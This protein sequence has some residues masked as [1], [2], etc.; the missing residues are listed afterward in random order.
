MTGVNNLPLFLASCVALNVMPG[1]D[2][3]YIVT[4]SVA[5]GRRAGLLSS[6][7]LCTGALLHTF[8]AALGLS[9]VL[10]ASAQ[11]FTLVKYAGALYLMYLGVKTFFDT[12][13]PLDL[14]TKPRAPASG[15]KIFLQGVVV[16]LL[17]PKV[18][19]FFLAFLPQFIDQRAPGKFGTFVSL[20]VILIM[21]SLVWEGIVAIASAELAGYL[22][23]NS[24]LSKRLNRVAGTLFF[25][26][27]LKLG[28]EKV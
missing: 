20:G 16:D 13:G 5:Q 15:G 24:S 17:N 28:L 1:P 19:L 21:F 4:R 14:D 8:A 12:S 23:S 6:W 10:A 27:G 2:T 7:G 11:A 26:L 18:A 3:I 25:G 22:T 9:A